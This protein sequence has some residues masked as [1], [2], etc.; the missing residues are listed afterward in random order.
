MNTRSERMSGSESE[1]PSVK[2]VVVADLGHLKAYRLEERSEFSRPRLELIQ[3]VE[4]TETHHVR[5]DLTD[6]IGRFRKEPAIPGAQSDGE[7]HNLELERQNRTVKMLAEVVSE[8]I[9][10]EHAANWYFAAD[11]RLNQS[12]LDEIDPVTRT[13]IQK[14]IVANLSKLD[15][16]ELVERFC[17]FKHAA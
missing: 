2:L 17:P 5:D 8:L 6:S 10:Q 3:A 7:E 14:N 9:A 16:E 1:N 15:P 13:K 4:T 11:A 12:L